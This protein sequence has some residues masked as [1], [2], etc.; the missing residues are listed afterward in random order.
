MPHGKPAGMACVQLDGRGR[1]QLFGR[2]DRP[3]V[4]LSLRPSLEMCAK[5]RTHALRWLARLEA[6]TAPRQ[7]KRS[8]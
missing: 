2:P 4:C 7:P 1:C 5:D 3:A 8:N 6:A